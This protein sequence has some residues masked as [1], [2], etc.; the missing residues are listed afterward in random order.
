MAW[1]ASEYEK[2]PAHTDALIQ[3]TICGVMVRSKSEAIIADQLYHRGIPFRYE[4]LI[5][6]N[7]KDHYP[8]FTIL[9]PGT[10]R[11]IVWEH[12]GMMS[13]PAYRYNAFKKLSSYSDGGLELDKDLIATFEWSDAPL[14]PL[15]VSAIIEHFFG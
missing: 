3:R 6:L 7:G 13:N 5:H 9:Q 12:F 2:N 1:K 4:S 11:Q 14:D 8:D 15:Y 10:L